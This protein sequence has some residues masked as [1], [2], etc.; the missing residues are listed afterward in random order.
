MRSI[1][2]ELYA[3]D[4]YTLDLIRGCLRNAGGEIVGPKAS[5]FSG[6]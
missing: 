4:G 3:F 6:I 1:G 5:S 2:R